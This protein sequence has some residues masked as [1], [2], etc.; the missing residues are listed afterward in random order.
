MLAPVSPKKIRRK[1]FTKTR[2]PSKTKPLANFSSVES[3]QGSLPTLVKKPKLG[4]FKESRLESMPNYRA[5]ANDPALEKKL[6][7]LNLDTNPTT[8]SSLH[9]KPGT[10]SAINKTPKKLPAMTLHR[11]QSA[12]LG[13]SKS[14]IDIKHEG[15][16]V[17]TTMTEWR[18]AH[19]NK[20]KLH[21]TISSPP[22]IEYYFQTLAGFS[23]GRTKINQDSVCVH[24]ETMSASSCSILAVFDGH[25]ALGHKVSDFL[26][27]NLVCK[28]K[29]T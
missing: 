18:D 22:Y 16:K 23:E 10:L 29:L 7:S 4:G 15:S 13:A 12:I 3:L 21:P 1:S 27:R 2:P 19:M 17:A 11:N 25:G 5:L 26:K 14:T 28:C 8:I 9:F 20:N 24:M 6:F